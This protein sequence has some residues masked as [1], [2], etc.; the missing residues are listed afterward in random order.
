[1]LDGRLATASG[2]SLAGGPHQVVLTAR[3]RRPGRHPDLP[4]PL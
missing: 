4:A 1:V 3:A 2:L